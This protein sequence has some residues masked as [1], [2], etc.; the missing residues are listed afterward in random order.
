LEKDLAELYPEFQA[1]PAV[2]IE[3]GKSTVARKIAQ[4]R[5]NGMMHAAE[6]DVLGVIFR[7]LEMAMAVVG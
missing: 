7:R 4:L 6:S 2:L 5:V 1:D 3:A